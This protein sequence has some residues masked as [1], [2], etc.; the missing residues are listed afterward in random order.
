MPG[1]KEEH[2]DGRTDRPGQRKDRVGGA[3]RQEGSGALA[4]KQRVPQDACRE[5]RR[6]PEAREHQRV[7]GE[8]RWTEDLGEEL[9]GVAQHRTDEPPVGAG[10][11][12]ET[13]R[14]GI[15]GRAEHHRGLAVERVR[16]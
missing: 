6:G 7:T 13:G 9:V 16:N 8:M 3:S 2:P 11:P 5:Q 10:V 1:E 4:A 15:R 12:A 14:G